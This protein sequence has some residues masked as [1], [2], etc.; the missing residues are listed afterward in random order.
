MKIRF[1][2]IM[3]LIFIPIANLAAKPVIAKW[4]AEDGTVV[5]SHAP[6]AKHGLYGVFSV[7]SGSVTMKDPLGGNLGTDG[8]RLN[9]DAVSRYLTGRWLCQ[10]QQG[11][12]EMEI[13]S[14]GY[15]EWTE[16]ADGGPGVLRRGQWD[17]D[18]L[19]LMLSFANQNL[20]GMD[21]DS[22]QQEVAS[23]IL[24]LNKFDGREMLLTRLHKDAGLPLLF[25]RLPGTA[26]ARSE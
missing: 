12:I 5:F 22:D 14:N 4:L 1:L 9:D 16:S 8:A 11:S 19:A 23:Q 24:K 17:I 7:N 25:T 6:P 10:W 13:D 2:A 3:S 15:V 18:D 21:I 20:G 26:L